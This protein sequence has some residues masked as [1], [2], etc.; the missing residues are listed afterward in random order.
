MSDYDTSM[1]SPIDHIPKKQKTLRTKKTEFLNVASEA[2]QLLNTPP[3]QDNE[4]TIVGKRF[5]FQL[6][7]MTEEQRLIAEKIIADVMYYGRRGKLTE[8]CFNYQNIV[9][10]PKN[11]SN[12]QIPSS[13][14][15]FNYQ[16]IHSHQ[17]IPQLQN[18]Y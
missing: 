15:Q 13:N 18:S 8:N 9:D 6:Q 5:A 3:D 12:Y 14:Q 7:S 1:L 11:M 2:I 10:P 4:C 16:T 17:Q